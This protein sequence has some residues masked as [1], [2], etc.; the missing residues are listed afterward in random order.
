MGLAVNEFWDEEG[1]DSD[2]YWHENDLDESHLF[3]LES[4]G[5]YFLDLS[6]EEATVQSVPV[7]VTLEQ[8]LWLGRYFVIFLVICA[9][10]AFIFYSL[11]KRRV[12]GSS[13][14]QSK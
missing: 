7:A 5:Q 12:V 2:G 11:S 14:V 13:L 4:P 1:R 3:K 9:V 10:L 6:M 8:G